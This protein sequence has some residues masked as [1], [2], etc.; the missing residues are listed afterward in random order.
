MLDDRV[1]LQ[2]TQTSRRRGAGRSL[3]SRAGDPRYLGLVSVAVLFVAWYL[4]TG[5][6]HVVPA[7]FLPSPAALVKEFV[8]LSRHGYAGTP[9][10]VHVGASLGRMLAGYALS[11]VVAVPLG[12]FMGINPVARGLLSPVFN[13]LRPIPTIALIPLMVLWFGIGEESKVIVIFLASFLFIVLN[14]TAGVMTVP[15]GLVRAAINLGANRVQLFWRVM[16]PAALPSIMTGLK[17][18][19]AVSWAVVV[20]A[21]LLGAQ[22]GIGYMI[23][24]AATFYRLQAVYVG[25][26]FIGAIGLVM[27][28]TL[29]LIEARVLHWAGKS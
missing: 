28:S 21:E 1:A 19:L 10:W 26:I 13:I 12:L 27:T 29:N 22:Q 7:K 11:I 17:T 2:S 16:F 20:A 24:D 5:P 9:L 4:F 25:V 3:G 8:D 14:T 15:E 18:G 6:Y 23:E